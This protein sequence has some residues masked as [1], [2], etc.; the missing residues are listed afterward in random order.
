MAFYDIQDILDEDQMDDVY[1]DVSPQERLILETI[2][3]TGD[4]KT[5]E[6]ALC[7]IDNTLQSFLLQMLQKHECI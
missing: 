7:V 6:T 1:F 3:S 2:D 5:P 4:G